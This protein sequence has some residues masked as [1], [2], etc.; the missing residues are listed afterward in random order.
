M[1]D[2]RFRIASTDPEILEKITINIESDNEKIY[3]YLK[4]NHPLDKTTVTNETINITDTDGYIMKTYTSYDIYRGCIV[5]CPIDS[6]LENK[7]YILKISTNFKSVSGISLKKQVYIM[8]IILNKKI[9]KYEILK[10]TAKI[11]KPKIRPIDYENIVNPKEELDTSKNKEI[12]KKNS[13]YKNLKINIILYI[14][15]FLITIATFYLILFL[16]F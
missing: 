7:N 9:S 6:Y 13:K 10:R 11:P 15:G 14:I 12:Y 5:V 2:D 8:F 1:V 16:I 3:W 4:F